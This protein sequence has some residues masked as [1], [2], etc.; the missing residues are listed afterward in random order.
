MQAF[1]WTDIPART[2]DPK[3]WWRLD[4]DNKRRLT[5]YYR[6]LALHVGVDVPAEMAGRIDHE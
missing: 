2:R 3:H 4:A 6:R 1:I 5:D